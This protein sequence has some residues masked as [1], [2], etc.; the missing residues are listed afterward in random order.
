M[1]L[2]NVYGPGACF[3]F[4]GL[5]GPA[6]HEHDFVGQLTADRLGV[7]FELPARR[8]LGFELAR[9]VREI[10]F[11]LV[12]NDTLDALLTRGG[13]TGYLRLAMA[14]HKAL[15]GAA[16][17][18]KPVAFAESCCATAETDGAL[19]TDG[20]GGFTALVTRDIGGEV[21]FAFAYDPASAGLAVERAKAV[22]AADL[23]ALIARRVAAYAALPPCPVPGG[24]VERAY[25]KA[26]SVLRHNVQTPEGLM[27]GLWTTPDR[28]PHRNM[29]LWDS[30]FHSFGLCHMDE[31]LAAQAVTAVLCRQAADGFI[32]HMM[33][34]TGCSDI[35]QPPLLA[36]ALARCVQRTG[37]LALARA[38]L[39][40]LRLYLAWNERR[41]D[42][43]ENDLCEWAI[44]GD[45]RCRSGESGMDNSPRFDAA[46]DM[47]AVD[48]SCFMKNEYDC[49]AD[50]EERL[51]MDEE[52]AEH[53]RK[54]ARIADAV[55]ELLWDEEK[56]IYCDRTMDGALSPV[57]SVASFL[58]LWAGI[59]TPQRATRLK[60]HLQNPAKFNTPVPLPSV[61]ADDPEYGTDMW[62]G[63][64]WMNYTY[65]ICQGLARYGM[66]DLS[67]DFAGRS[68][69]AMARWY[70]RCGSLYEY[71]HAQDAMPPQTMD[72]KGPTTPP[73]D[74]RRKIFAIADYGWTAAIY[75]ALLREG[76]LA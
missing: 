55:N 68:V 11:R 33:T 76:Y 58:P 73:V 31:A 50:M 66:T 21:R 27:T 18:A 13:E 8:T 62:R 32:P 10:T 64:V 61:S 63:G 56:G 72:R 59:A 38:Y 74:L 47:D 9:G 69:A 30:A 7:C 65:M 15:L 40:R 42:R 35:T 24:D 46:A 26:F 4:S 16:R 48:F 6:G 52:A 70:R 3:G 43:N 44:E 5:E 53:R 41:R 67:K 45:P 29:W 22:L 49:L 14:E 23:D 39:P 1:L 54:A 37:D 75:I 25:Y 36:W 2:P 60:D 19:V 34:P 57:M 28:I 12:V 17:F 51:S 71:Y 20:P